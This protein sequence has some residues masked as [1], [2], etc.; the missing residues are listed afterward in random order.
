MIR[1]PKAAACTEH[2]CLIKLLLTP[3]FSEGQPSALV[4]LLQRSQRDQRLSTASPRPGIS[5]TDSVRPVAAL[6]LL[7]AVI[8][9][10][11]LPEELA[12][13]LGSCL[14]A[15][16][17]PQ[18]SAAQCHRLSRATWTLAHALRGHIL[19]LQLGLWHETVLH[20]HPTT[21]LTESGGDG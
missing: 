15:E 18:T 21:Q 9:G 1:L 2:R 7:P 4:I 11:E 5:F 12:L 16:M 13:L 6:A 20:P 3:K 10:A 17:R 8:W 14:A 19:S